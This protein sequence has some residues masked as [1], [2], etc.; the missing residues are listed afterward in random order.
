MDESICGYL[1]SALEVTYEPYNTQL[2]NSESSN[3]YFRI[4]GTNFRDEVRIQSGIASSL[5]NNLSPSLIM[6]DEDTPAS[7]IEIDGDDVR[8][9]LDLLNR[10]AAYYGAARQTL[11]LKVKHPTVNNQPAALPLLKLNGISPDTKKYLPLAES[12]DWIADVATLKCFETP[13]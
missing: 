7:T 8:P 3:N 11:E 5:N 9:E 6:T 10:L 2:K 13:E 1:L 12:R 4:L